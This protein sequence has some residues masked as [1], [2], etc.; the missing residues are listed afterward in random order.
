M[1]FFKIIIC[2]AVTAAILLLAACGDKKETTGSVSETTV[3]SS[4][5]SLAPVE[6]FFPDKYITLAGG[7]E[8]ITVK[9]NVAVSSNGKTS[10]RFDPLSGEGEVLDF[11]LAFES[12]FGVGS[13]MSL[14]LTQFDLSRGYCLALG[15]DGAVDISEIGTS[16]L[17]AT[18][19][20]V[21]GDGGTVS[22]VAASKIENIK[23]AADSGDGGALSELG[24]GNDFL[25]VTAESTDYKTV[26]GFTVSHYTF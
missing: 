22:Y 26:A 9:G 11:P 12:G 2:T 1:R 25:I 15:N 7:D 5:S 6:V 24:I 23:F 21:L 20:I 16:A 8:K 18:A 19:V 10:R 3:S 13:D 14:F 4:V 17:S